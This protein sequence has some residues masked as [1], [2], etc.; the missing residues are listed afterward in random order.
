MQRLV[1]GVLLAVLAFAYGL[2]IAGR[3]LL[4]ASLAA[5]ILLAT[6][7][8]AAPG[9]DVDRRKAATWVVAGLVVAYGAGN[10]EFLLG[11]LVATVVYYVS[12]VT[13]DD[14]VW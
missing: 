5:G 13:R 11:V 7:E 12:W 6:W 1:G 10:H 14:P 2:L 3:P 8:L 9:G 4:G